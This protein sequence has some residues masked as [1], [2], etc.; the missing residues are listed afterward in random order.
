MNSASD[1]NLF[2]SYPALGT[3]TEIEINNL[4]ML[5]LISILHL[6]LEHSKSDAVVAGQSKSFKAIRSDNLTS[7]CAT[8]APNE[9]IRVEDLNLPTTNVISSSPETLCAWR[10]TRESKCTGFNWKSCANE[11]EFYSYVPKA[12]ETIYGCTHYRVSIA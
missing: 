6:M 7:L 4:Q 2:F 9:V 11:C 10:C 8:N 1:F 12:C 3:V 5:L